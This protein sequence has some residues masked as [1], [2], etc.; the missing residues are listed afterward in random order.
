M[1]SH[2]TYRPEIDG[3]RALAVLAILLHHAGVAWLPGGYLGVDLFFVISGFVITRLIAAE[4]EA[5]T[6]SLAGFWRRRAR[7]IVPALAVLLLATLIAAWVMMSPAQMKDFLPVFFG[8][9][10]MVPNIV[11]WFD[12]GY[13]AQ[14]AANRPLLHLWSLGVEEQFYLLYPL[15][16]L[17]L[18]TLRPRARWWSLLALATASLLA[19]ATL[20]AFAPSAGFYLL[21]SRIW[22]LVT[23]ALAAL[24]LWRPAGRTAQA[25]ALAALVLILVPMLLFGPRSP[26]LATLPPVLGAALCLMAARPDTWVGRGL[27]TRPLV[28]IGKASYGAYLWHWP[29]LAFARI[30]MADEPSLTA[31]LALTGGA[32]VLGWASWRWIEAPFRRGTEPVL[33]RVGIIGAIFGLG[34]LSGLAAL[35]TLGEGLG[36]RTLTWPGIQPSQIE[37]IAQERNDLV[38]NGTCHLRD[39][40]I[41]FQEFRATWNCQAVSGDGLTGWP[42]ALY[43]DS[44]ASDVGMVLRLTGRNPMQMSMHGCSLVPSQMRPDCRMAADDLRAA[45]KAAGIDTVV[46]ANLWQQAELTP[47]ALVEL[48]IWWHEA[49]E[50]VVL[51]SPLP[52]YPALDERLLRWPKDKVAALPPDLSAADSFAAARKRTAGSDLLIIDA[53]SLFCGER[54]GCSPQGEGPLML[55]GLAHLTPEGARGH[56]S[57]LEATGLLQ[58]LGQ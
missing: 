50:T 42:V 40:T 33:P 52:R 37:A 2:T 57:R 26:G 19:A 14:D 20:V 27:V 38:R 44:N 55:D 34:A 10:T 29:L 36:W 32:L 54:P 8:A 30:H 51:V 3:L 41:P 6:F 31:K 58:R 17:A 15:L 5:G 53:A 11:L 28:Q 48:E 23:G 21:P 49:F 47:S 1:V 7:R 13:F 4:L 12:V 45:A 25:W 43:G 18:W 35:A 46:L 9:A 16:L 24:S 39:E 22:E 56:A